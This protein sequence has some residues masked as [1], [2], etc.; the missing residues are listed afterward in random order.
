[1]P[2]MSSSVSS[3]KPFDR[4]CI[5]MKPSKLPW[6]A[7]VLSY[8]FYFGVCKPA[9]MLPPAIQ[10]FGESMIHLK[11]DGRLMA[12]WYF[13]LS[14]FLPLP[15]TPAWAKY[16][17]LPLPLSAVIKYLTWK[18][19]SAL[20]LHF[21]PS[22][23]F[24]C[25]PCRNAF[26][27]FLHLCAMAPRSSRSFQGQWEVWPS[28]TEKTAWSDPRN[29]TRTFAPWESFSKP[30]I[31]VKRVMSCDCKRFNVNDKF[32][33]GSNGTPLRQ[34]LL[35]KWAWTCSFIDKLTWSML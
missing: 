24:C 18:K 8:S 20:H 35:R 12:S 30:E 7:S 10:E 32:S 2:K 11:A 5:T 14:P 25:L 26:V 16:L 13:T 29:G 33:P 22:L 9:T 4:C 34:P 23:L 3:S 27:I 19:R 21:V 15:A 31:G 1:M 6:L 28:E 17:S